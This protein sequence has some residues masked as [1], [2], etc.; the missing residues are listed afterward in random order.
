MT[1]VL[2]RKTC[3]MTGVITILRAMSLVRPAMT[4]HHDSLCTRQAGLITD[5]TGIAMWLHLC[6]GLFPRR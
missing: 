5:S 1:L 3:V 4:T 6:K 2:R